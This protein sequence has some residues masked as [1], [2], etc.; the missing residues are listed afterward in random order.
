MTFQNIFQNKIVDK[1]VLEKEEYLQR[2]N[3]GLCVACGGYNNMKPK[4]LCSDCQ[5]QKNNQKQ[6]KRKFNFIGKKE[7]E[8][9]KNQGYCV[10]CGWENDRLPKVVCSKC[11]KYQK[12][13]REKQRKIKKIQKQKEKQSK[14]NEAKR[15]AEFLKLKNKNY[16]EKI[17]PHPEKSQKYNQPKKPI[18]W[19]HN[20]D[21]IKQIPNEPFPKQIQKAIQGDKI[22]TTNNEFTK[23][24]ELGRRLGRKKLYEEINELFDEIAT[25]SIN[26]DDLKNILKLI[27]A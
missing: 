13:Y 14:M 8:Y 20:E 1:M 6:T 25:E 10:N 18:K 23:G 12:D 27:K 19:T 9:R 3:A 24:F 11:A 21:L 7:Y 26:A 4:L 5:T 15:N 17:Q 2:K 22:K 16:T